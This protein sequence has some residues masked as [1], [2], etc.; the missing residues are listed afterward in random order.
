MA[1]QPGQ[2]WYCIIELPIQSFYVVTLLSNLNA[3]GYVRGRETEWHE[4]LSVLPDESITAA[5][6]T[7]SKTRQSAYVLKDMVV[8]EDGRSSTARRS[9]GMNKVRTH[10]VQ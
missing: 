7:P 2:L 4:Y 8:S 6:S 9:D 1:S 10:R 3:R 5:G